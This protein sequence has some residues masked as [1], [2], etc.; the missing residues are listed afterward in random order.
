MKQISLTL[1]ILIFLFAG[2]GHAQSNYK[3]GIVI[4]SKGDTLKG[5]INYRE[6]SSSP[7]YCEFKTDLSQKA[8]RFYPNSI[9][10]FEIAGLEKYLAYSGRIS[11][12]KNVFPDVSPSLD[13]TTTPDTIFLKFAYQGRQVSL[14]EQTDNLKQR[15]F[16]L[17]NGRQPMELKFYQYYRNDNKLM[18][19]N[20]FQESLLRLAE[21]YN[22]T[23]RSL[24]SQIE[25]SRFS[26][27][28]I[29]SIIKKIN[30]DNSKTGTSNTRFY[31]GV[32]LG[33]AKTVFSG[34]TPFN[35]T[36]STDFMPGLSAGLDFFTNINTQKMFFRAE[37]SV[38][39]TRAN[40]TNAVP[41]AYLATSQQQQ[42]K[43][44]QYTA[45]L[46]PGVFCNIY[47]KEG[48][49][50]FFGVGV[51]FNFS[52]YNNNQ[53]S[54]AETVYPN[55]Y[56]LEKLWINFPLQTGVTITKKWDVFARYTPPVAFERYNTISIS[57]EMYGLGVYYHF[58][59]IN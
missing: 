22:S 3:P 30:Q 13:T 35:G 52:I 18:V 4:Q 44:E 54:F 1:F 17:E 43:F 26:V 32:I 50:V 33:Q 23:D 7:E 25:Y 21:R 53:L 11:M 40:V 27:S 56:D 31:A 8:Q 34:T 14:L 46:T 15:L 58:S 47:N 38:W 55:Y 2:I 42:Y 24:I 5:L 16:I 45:S 39:T 48:F 20:L 28:N 19:V 41:T 57:H 10:S 59:K 9:Q 36:S 37:L 51:S 49:K 6:W 12:D 29:T